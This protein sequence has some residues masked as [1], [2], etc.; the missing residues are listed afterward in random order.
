[1]SSR[2]NNG[3]WSTHLSGLF[4]L[5]LLP[6]LATQE[7][8]SRHLDKHSVPLWSGEVPLPRDAPVVLSSRPIKLNADPFSRGE[9]GLAHETDRSRSCG[10]GNQQLSLQDEQG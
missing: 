4:L 6:L 9:A 5:L 8:H 7:P 2:I 3:Q 1:M 10:G